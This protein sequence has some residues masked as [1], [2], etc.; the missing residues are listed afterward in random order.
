MTPPEEDLQRDPHQ[1]DIA[2]KLS[3]DTSGLVNISRR[4]LIY[5][6]VFKDAR[7]TMLFHVKCNGRRSV[8]GRLRTNKSPD[9]W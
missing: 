5:S 1:V 4:C 7:K 2:L 6:T 3:P 8:S 9:V